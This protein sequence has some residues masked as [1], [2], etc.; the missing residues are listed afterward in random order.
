MLFVKYKHLKKTE[1]GGYQIKDPLFLI[2]T[3][4]LQSWS[5]ALPSIT[6]GPDI[7]FLQNGITVC[8]QFFNLCPLQPIYLNNLKKQFGAPFYPLA[9]FTQ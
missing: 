6:T 9:E 4:T 7:H 5:L 8:T 1:I 3:P 2:S